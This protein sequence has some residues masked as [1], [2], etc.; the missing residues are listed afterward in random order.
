MVKHVTFT[1]STASTNVLLLFQN[2]RDNTTVGTE[3]EI[4]SMFKLMKLGSFAMRLLQ[5]ACTVLGAAFNFSVCCAQTDGHKASCTV[6]VYPT[7]TLTS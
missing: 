6:Q 5:G 7:L 1:N 4:Q 2:A 3:T